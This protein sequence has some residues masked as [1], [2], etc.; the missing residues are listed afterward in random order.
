MKKFKFDEQEFESAILQL[1]A[2]IQASVQKIHPQKLGIEP[3]DLVQEIRI[4]LW[5]IFKSE[6]KISNH[7]S[8]I[9]KAINSI[10]IDQI[11]DSRRH[12]RTLEL[13]KQRTLQDYGSSHNPLD[14]KNDIGQAVNTLMES[15]RR[16]VKLFLLGMSIGEISAMLD[17][18]ESGT[19]NL[20]YRGLKDLKDIMKAKGVNFDD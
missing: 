5:K 12:E 18:S 3:D 4:K 1:S 11:R 16:V 14:I 8:Y 9:K 19:R 6:K 17:M 20:L 13:E 15:R 2:I 7:S 10:I